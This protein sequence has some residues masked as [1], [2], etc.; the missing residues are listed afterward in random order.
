MLLKTTG[1]VS[2]VVEDINR[3]SKVIAKREVA[4]GWSFWEF[5]RDD[6][7]V[8]DSVLMVTLIGPKADQRLFVAPRFPAQN[9]TVIEV[10]DDSETLFQVCFVTFMIEIVRLMFNRV[11]C[12]LGSSFHS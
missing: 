11:S 5:A 12:C 1:N 3:V 6:R 7:A 10:F 2:F 8:H 4:S 9:S